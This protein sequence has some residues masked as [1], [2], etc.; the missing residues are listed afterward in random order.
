LG[1]AAVDALMAGR[2]NQTIGIVNNEVN[3]TSFE[4]AIYKKKEIST[5]LLKL[6]EILSM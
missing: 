1:S 5:D 2:K 6:A 4:D 3:F